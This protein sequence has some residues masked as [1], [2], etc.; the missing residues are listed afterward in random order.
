[1]LDNL[2]SVYTAMAANPDL[3]CRIKAD[4]G[5]GVN[6]RISRYGSTNLIRFI[7][8]MQHTYRSTDFIITY[9]FNNA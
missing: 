9:S 1:M 6:H 5:Y 4:G 3:V 7:S 8:L 2:S